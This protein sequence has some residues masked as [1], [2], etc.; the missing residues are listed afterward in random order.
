[1]AQAD[2]KRAP[3]TPQQMAPAVLGPGRRLHILQDDTVFAI[4]LCTTIPAH[5]PLHAAFWAG[6]LAA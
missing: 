4:R 6:R 3:K 1:M 2:G 5:E